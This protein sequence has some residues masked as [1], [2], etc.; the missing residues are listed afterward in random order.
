MRIAGI[1]ALAAL[2][3]ATAAVG[4]MMT[5][6]YV[7]IGES[8]G[9]SGKLST[10]GTIVEVDREDHTMTVDG[11]RGRRTY[12][13]MDT[14]HIWLDRSSWQLT[15]VTGS[16]RDCVE[17]RRVEVLRRQDDEAVADWVKIE[18]RDTR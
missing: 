11:E 13:I 5:E 10:I 8:P 16:Y 6:R 3:A 9:V 7:P 4:Q 2:L 17:G 15:N 14:T 18:S 1:A 12:R